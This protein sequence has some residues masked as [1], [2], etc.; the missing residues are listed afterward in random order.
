MR[1][2]FNRVRAIATRWA[3]PRRAS[4][5]RET[6]NQW[7]VVRRVHNPAMGAWMDQPVIL[8]SSHAA[9]LTVKREWERG[10]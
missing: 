4:V 5:R 7:A 2:F 8:F 9:A 10:E 3:N 6:E 1:G